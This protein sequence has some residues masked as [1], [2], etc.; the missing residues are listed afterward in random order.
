[1]PA[2]SELK[3]GRAFQSVKLRWRIMAGTILQ[4]CRRDW[5]SIAAVAADNDLSRDEI[6]L[7]ARTFA[8]Y[9]TA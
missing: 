3:S 5:L 1:M 8:D 9:L 6:M 2:I 7:V 4:T